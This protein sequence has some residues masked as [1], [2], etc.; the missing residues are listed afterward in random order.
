MDYFTY[1][2]VEFRSQDFVRNEEKYI[3]FFWTGFWGSFFSLLV[4][5]RLFDICIRISLLLV[6][7]PTDLYQSL[8]FRKLVEVEYARP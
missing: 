8:E 3:L 5:D 2:T 6:Q 4:L 7:G 1:G